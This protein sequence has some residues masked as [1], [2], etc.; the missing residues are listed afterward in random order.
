MISGRQTK[1]V[2]TYPKTYQKYPALNS[3]S[4]ECWPVAWDLQRCSLTYFPEGLLPDRPPKKSASSLP[5]YWIFLFKKFNKNNY[6][7]IFGEAGGR[8]IQANA[9]KGPIHPPEQKQ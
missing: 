6:R 8:L 3:Q 9:R 5:R 7:A 4:A 1:F 2:R